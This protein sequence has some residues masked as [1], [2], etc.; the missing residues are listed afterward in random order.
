MKS[1]GIGG[2]A[3]LEGVMMRNRSR[4]AVAVRK[5][6]GEI[7][8]V[9][10]ETKSVR[11]KALFFRLPVIRGVV[12]FV[13]SLV[14]G[15]KTLTYS[16]EIIEEEEEK[17]A[18]GKEDS[19][20]NIRDTV[21]NVLIVLLS[22]LLAVGLFLL[23]PFG[24]SALLRSKIHSQTTLTLLEGVLKIVLFLGYVVAI[25]LLGDIRRVFMYHGAE[26]KTINCVEKGLDLTVANVK[27][28]KR[29]H[30]RC[31]T[32]FLFVVILVSIL[33]CLLIPETN[34]WLGMLCRVLMIPVVAGV[35]YEFI[36]WA[37]NTDN[38]VASVLSIPGMW[39]QKLTTR[40]PEDDMIE[41][42]ISSVEAVF[43]WRKY[44]EE[45][46]TQKERKARRKKADRSGAE[47]SEVSQK[48]KK[49]RNQKRRE[50]EEREAEYK[51]RAEERKRR[52]EEQEEKEKQH[53][54]LYQAAKKRTAERLAATGE[55]PSLEKQPVPAP[56]VEVESDG[57]ELKG[58]DHFLDRQK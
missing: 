19:R 7:M 1:S 21:E 15:L 30:K 57:E 50:L 36:L 18:S 43:D 9:Q 29:Y 20:E 23:L 58:L 14:L 46:R 12:A 52:R 35:S 16:S 25:S 10:K 11:E 54:Q 39:I 22:V 6:D 45:L 28:Q 44:Q 17:N 3:V 33:F 37:G 4:Y 48:R 31:G 24:V 8:V 27:K 51:D 55:L 26:H 49:T 40:E 53:K 2:Q 5:P 41:V 13:E 32:S 42:A 34:V 47:K 56:K 38:F